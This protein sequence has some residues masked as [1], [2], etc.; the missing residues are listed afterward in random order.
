[1]TNALVGTEFML[2]CMEA[3]ELTDKYSHELKKTGNRFKAEVTKYSN[4]EIQVLLDYDELTT[5]AHMRKL[6]DT[7]RKAV[8]LEP[9][10]LAALAEVIKKLR[11]HPD[12]T[13]YQLGILKGT[14]AEMPELTRKQNLLNA[15]M[16]LSP[17]HVNAVTTFVEQ[18]IK[19]N[20]Q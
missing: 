19:T 16:E 17:E 5:Y 8:Y 3:L 2:E 11:A 12:L 6:S 7:F 9:S 4:N 1:M 15:V 18:L 20:I 10:S 14:T 13:F